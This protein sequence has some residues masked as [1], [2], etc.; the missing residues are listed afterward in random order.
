MT[1]FHGAFRRLFLEG[2]MKS[3][4]LKLKDTHEGYRVWVRKLNKKYLKNKIILF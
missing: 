4:L 1:Y 3:Q 2:G